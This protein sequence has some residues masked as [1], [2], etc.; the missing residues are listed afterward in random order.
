MGMNK[1]DV[2]AE[3]SDQ[4]EPREPFAARR[5][6]AMS[7]MAEYCLNADPETSSKSPSTADRYQVVVHGSAETLQKGPA[8]EDSPHINENISQIEGGPHVSAETSRRIACDCS[9][10]K[11]LDDEEGE[12]LSIGRKS[13]SIPPAIRRA[14][15]FRDKGCRFPG[16][17]H[18]DFIDGHHIKHWAD[19]GETSIDNLVQ[20]CRHHHR[21]IHE[22]GFDCHRLDDGKIVFR[23]KRQTIMPDFIRNSPNLDARKTDHWMCSTYAHL[24]IDRHT[25]VTQWTSGGDIDWNLDVGNL[26][27]AE[28][29]QLSMN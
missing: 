18:K 12:P 26:F 14:L 16:C 23:D 8:A 24:N 5:A 21:L 25:C 17:T 11:V 22:G 6:D 15:R 1:Q 20:L 28:I 7:K 4:S 2:S 3:T 13:R 10:L 29:G 27:L 9:I 19:G